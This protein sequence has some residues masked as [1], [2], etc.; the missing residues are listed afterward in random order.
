M[1][2]ITTIKMRM[3]DYTSVDNNDVNIDHDKLSNDNSSI[4]GPM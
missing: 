2:M 1:Q 3:E 4:N